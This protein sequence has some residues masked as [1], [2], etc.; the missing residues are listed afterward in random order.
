MFVTAPKTDTCHNKHACQGVFVACVFIFVS[1]SY[2]C[3]LFGARNLHFTDWGKVCAGG[4]LHF[5]RG[6]VGKSKKKGLA[7]AA[8]MHFIITN[9]TLAL[10]HS[11][12]YWLSSNANYTCR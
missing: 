10:G 11:C 5:W 9:F 3:V 8:I 7:N 12:D 4:V 2:F 6:E 1:D